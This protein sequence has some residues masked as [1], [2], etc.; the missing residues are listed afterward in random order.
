MSP[1]WQAQTSTEQQSASIPMPTPPNT[2]SLQGHMTATGAKVEEPVESERATPMAGT[3]GKP[4]GADG[5]V[6]MADAE[7]GQGHRRTDHERL[8]E[9]SVPAKGAT[10]SVLKVGLFKLPTK[11]LVRQ[12]PHPSSD[13]LGLYNLRDVQISVQRKD[14]ITGEKVN[15]LRKSYEGKLKD[16]DL[17]GRNKATESNR[18]LEG[19]V[20]ADWD[21]VPDGADKTFWDLRFPEEVKLGSADHDALLGKLNKAF[22]LKPGRLPRSEHNQWSHLL[23]TDDTAAKAAPVTSTVP[24]KAPLSKF[25][26]KTAP[27]VI[28]GR[29]APSSPQSAAG[30]T[31][32]KGAKRRYD[33]TAF[34]GYD[35]DGYS[36][37]GLDDRGAAKRRKRQVSTRDPD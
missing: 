22:S 34:E 21:R 15:R 26:T 23:G 37:G 27:A 28:A 30:R 2:A 29:S 4:G 17:A 3:E 35:E 11:P 12:R 18:I 16:L 31:Q 5:D 33:D 24:A 6:E 20:D 1:A 36:T 13:L 8:A 9:G 19:L 32:R 7:A 25:M 14:P 10:A